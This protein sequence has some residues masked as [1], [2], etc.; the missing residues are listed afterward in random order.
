MEAAGALLMSS[1]YFRGWQ[2][3]TDGAAQPSVPNGLINIAV[4]VG[5]HR[6]EVWWGPSTP[7]CIAVDKAGG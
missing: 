2:V 1:T 4:P 7:R 6:V 5:D 3:R